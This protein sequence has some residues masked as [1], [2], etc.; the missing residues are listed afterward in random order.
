[1]NADPYMDEVKNTLYEEVLLRLDRTE[2]RKSVLDFL[3]SKV[4]EWKIDWMRL[5]CNN[6]P[7]A[8]W[9]ANEPDGCRGKIQNQYCAGLYGLLDELGEKCPN[10]HIETCAGGGRRMDIGM[11]RRANSAWMSDLAKDYHCVRRF[12]VNLNRFVPGFANSVFITPRGTENSAIVFG[13]DTFPWES[14]YSKFAGPL[15]FSEISSHFSEKGASQL[16][17]IIAQFKAVRSY[18]LKDFH[19]LFDPCS[20]NDYDGWQFHD[21]ETGS[22]IFMV[23][24]CSSPKKSMKF[25][26]KGL[27]DSDYEAEN[28]TTHEKQKFIPKRQFEVYLPNRKDVAWFHYK[29]LPR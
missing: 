25:F 13:T 27:S 28:L 5:D 9:D 20:I 6:T 15:G 26:L 12:Q 23:F 4:H 7:G 16:K 3:V 1:M 19:P 21:P 24:R 18:L 11:L 14:I 8:F 2:V 29:K 17:K 10:L 22:G